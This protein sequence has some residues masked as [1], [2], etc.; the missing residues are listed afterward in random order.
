ML[1]YYYHIIILLSYYYHIIMLYYIDDTVRQWQTGLGSV[2]VLSCSINI[3]SPRELIG[4][5]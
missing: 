4:Q 2:A 1:S 5:G 3:D